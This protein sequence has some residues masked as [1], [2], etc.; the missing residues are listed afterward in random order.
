MRCCLAV[1]WSRVD[2]VL[3]QAGDLTGT[4]IVNCCLPMNADDGGLA[5]ATTSSGS[6]ELAKK[7]H[8]AR[9]VSAFNT[10]PSEVLFGVFDA[11]HARQKPSLVYCGDDARA[12]QVAAK[13]IHDVGF[14]PIRCRATAH[15][16]IYGAV[17]TPR[18]SARL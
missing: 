6:E 14:D 5:V 12:K 1:H 13:L 7:A 10:V 16:A 2:D 11:R 8:G 18:G 3:K 15:G 9:V 17:R 4:V